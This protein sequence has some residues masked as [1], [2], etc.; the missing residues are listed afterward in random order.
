[1]SSTTVFYNL[2]DIFQSIFLFYD[3]VGNLVNDAL[4]LLGFVGFFIWMNYQR[5][6]NKQ[7]QENS[8]QIK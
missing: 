6:F 1:M 8:N 2:D 7:A 5:K 4:L 3:N